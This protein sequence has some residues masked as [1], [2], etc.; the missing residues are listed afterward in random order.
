[1]KIKIIMITFL[2]SVN[3]SFAEQNPFEFEEIDTNKSLQNTG[4]NPMMNDPDFGGPRIEIFSQPEDRAKEF[5]GIS[6]QYKLMVTVNDVEIYHNTDTDSYIHV[7][8][9][10][11]QKK[12][13]EYKNDK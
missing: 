8:L 1:M 9:N 6:S 13:M 7:D 11:L 3:I 4:G 12:V 5:F 2:L 10:D